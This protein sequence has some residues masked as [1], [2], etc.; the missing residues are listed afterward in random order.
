LFQR[1]TEVDFEKMLT[2]F[3][4]KVDYEMNQSVALKIAEITKL[5]VFNGS[6]TPIA[7][8]QTLIPL[9]EH[10]LE[11]AMTMLAEFAQRHRVSVEVLISISK[12]LLE[13]M[14]ISS[15]SHL[16]RH[17]YHRVSA[18]KIKERFQAQ[19]DFALD[20]V[21]KGY[22]SGRSV[23]MPEPTMREQ[24]LR[25]LNALYESS[26]KDFVEPIDLEQVAGQSGMSSSEAEAASKYLVASGL[27]EHT[28]LS[29][30][31]VRITRAGIG[32]IE[33]ALKSPEKETEHL[34]SMNN[35]IYVQNMIGSNIQQATTGSSQKIEI[36]PAG[37]EQL[38][39]LITDLDDAVSALDGRPEQKELRAEV[40]TIKSQLEKKQPSTL[41][42]GESLRSAKAMIEGTIAGVAA[43][44]LSPSLVPAITAALIALGIPL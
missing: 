40:D 3:V 16:A 39:I 11:Q 18:E 24:G 28:S 21:S 4:K 25:L 35:T 10:A 14:T 34:S 15:I 6:R 19:I 32:E 1:A 29:N 7:I 27:A 13:Q 36:T 33:E 41:I 31:K 43:N 38:R 22:V 17:D 26:Q 8:E 37:L 42:V 12:P 5:G 20:M 2:S 23:I 30:Q 9:H 44:V